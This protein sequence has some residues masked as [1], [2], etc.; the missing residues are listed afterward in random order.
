MLTDLAETAAHDFKAWEKDKDQVA[1]FTL[2][3]LTPHLMGIVIAY[4][5]MKFSKDELV[6]RVERMAAAM[7]EEGS[8]ISVLWRTIEAIENANN[9][10]ETAKTVVYAARARLIV[11]TA[12]WEIRHPEAFS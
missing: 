10:I 7:I 6:E 1:T 11:A 9:F 3:G 8:D 12:A 5:L 4:R 2:E